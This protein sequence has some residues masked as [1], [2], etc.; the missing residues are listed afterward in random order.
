[1]VGI[2]DAYCS[3]LQ[4]DALW[5]G[6]MTCYV[7]KMQEMGLTDH[8]FLKLAEDF[9]MPSF[10][11]LFLM[12]A[13][14]EM[15]VCWTNCQANLLNAP[16]RI[17]A[18]VH[19]KIHSKT[20]MIFWN[21]WI[22]VKPLELISKKSFRSNCESIR[23]QSCVTQSI[24]LAQGLTGTVPFTQYMLSATFLCCLLY[25]RDFS[26]LQG[27]RI[28]FYF[29]FKTSNRVTQRTLETLDLQILGR[30]QGTSVAPDG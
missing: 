28:V 11:S 4:S 15:P 29:I 6:T 22:F 8:R 19:R 30:N 3:Q 23:K 16:F 21:V 9:W 20:V 17:S 13:A 14:L 27:T 18:W 1:M 2:S 26:H 12:P 25:K 24:W 5:C 10:L 7:L